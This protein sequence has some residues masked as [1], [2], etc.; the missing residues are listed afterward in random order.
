MRIVKN[1]NSA[2]MDHDSRGDVFKVT[3]KT[4]W[5]F[6]ETSDMMKLYKADRSALFRKQK[7]VTR[8]DVRKIKLRCS[9]SL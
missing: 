3:S 5:I 4:Y 1:L 2:L 9:G 7:F 8:K 6:N